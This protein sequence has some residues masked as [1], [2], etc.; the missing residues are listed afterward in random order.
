MTTTA[1]PRFDIRKDRDS[2]WEIF[3]T[4]NGRTVLVSGEPCRDLALNRA[5]T[6]A[7]YMNSASMVLDV[8][9]LH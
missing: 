9:T 2:T 7:A 1:E 5:S 6:L 8:E 4:T 3:D